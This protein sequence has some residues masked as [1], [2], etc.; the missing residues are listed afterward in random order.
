MS[1]SMIGVIGSYLPLLLVAATLDCHEPEK[2]A[3]YSRTWVA[4]A[5]GQAHTCALDAEGRI[6]C[7]GC[8]G[9]GDGRCLTPPGRYIEIVAGHGKTRGVQTKLDR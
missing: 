6:T 8:R 7:W 3:D 5:A 2:V 4:L 1:A 9:Y